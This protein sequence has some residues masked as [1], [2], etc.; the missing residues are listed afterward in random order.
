MDNKM[1]PKLRFPGFSGEWQLKKLG[2]IGE[3]IIGLTYSPSD[4]SKNNNGIIVLRSCNIKDK[5]LQFDDIVRVKEGTKISAQQQIKDG[6]IL[7]CT[8]NGSQRLIGKC[9]QLYGFRGYT[10]G[11]FMSVFRSPL[12]DFVLMLFNTS[13]YKK[14]IQKDLGARINQ[15][16]T[17]QLNKYRFFFPKDEEEQIK[18]V[19]FLSLVDEKIMA[20]GKKIE[21]MKKYKKSIFLI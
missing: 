3:N 14:Q 6:D 18:I 1:T 17:R 8:R 21:L 4:V 2:D 12:N 7:I 19:K 11:A 16:T 5:G 20:I 10:F 15:I 13:S 9:Y